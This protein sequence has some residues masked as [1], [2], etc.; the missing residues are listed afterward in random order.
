MQRRK[1]RRPLKLALW[2]VLAGVILL[3]VILVRCAIPK[4]AQVPPAPTIAVMPEAQA[5]ASPTL[6]PVVYTLDED[7]VEM[8]AQMLWGE[9]RGI[10]SD[11]EKAACVWCVLN[12]VDDESGV[13]PNTVAEVLTQKN[14]FAG[15]SADYPATDELKAL[16]ADV[17]TRWQ[18]EKTEGSGVGRVLPANYFFF[19][20]DGQ[21]NYFRAEYRDTETW[22]WLLPSPYEN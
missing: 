14:Q 20:G 6:V 21:R 4:P 15:Y 17:M 1:R 18:Q 22:D 9:A 5:S 13:W 2:L 7:D 12:R 3:S 8:L 10:P 19:T 16:A 11:M